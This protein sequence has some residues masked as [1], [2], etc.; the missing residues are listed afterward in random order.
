MSPKQR[1]AALVLIAGAAGVLA[2][3]CSANSSNDGFGGGSGGTD[4]TDASVGGTGGGSGGESGTG[5]TGG[6]MILPEA[7]ISD[8]VNETPVN[9][10]G[11]QCGPVELCEPQFIG[12]DDNCNGQVDEGCPCTPGLSHWCFKGDPASRN[13]GACK[14]G[15]QKCGENGTWGPCI[16]GFHADAIDNC[17]NQNVPD[18]CHDLTA[19]PFTTVT[20]KDGTGTF[21]QGATGESFQVTCPSSIPPANCPQTQNPDGPTATF[22]PLQLGQ[23]EVLYSKDDG[24]GGKATCTFS[25]YVGATGLRVELN[26]DHQ[27]E[28]KAGVDQNG[29]PDGT[30]GP[31]LDL[32]VHRPGVQSKWFMN[33]LQPFAPPD[34]CYYANC[35]AGN[36]VMAVP[37]MASPNWFSDT[38]YP[39]N[40]TYRQPY[41]PNDPIYTCY[42]A[43][44]GAGQE[45]KMFNKGCH[46]PRLDLDNITCDK[47]KTNPQDPAFC[48]PENINIDEPPYGL[49]TRIGV[50]YYG[51][52]YAGDLHPTVTIYCAGA[53]VAQ[54]GPN[55]Y[56]GP[57]TFKA[58][59]CQGDD[60]G[61]NAFW[62]VADVMAVE[63]PCGEVECVVQPIYGDLGTKAPYIKPTSFAKGNFGPACAP[64]GD[65]GVGCF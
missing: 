33:P 8:V 34:D 13:K 31:D 57:V 4:T 26:W 16:G 47:T 12:Y 19:A 65:A 56:D 14:D 27:G 40:W 42:N 23:Y 48:A 28:G 22:T 39:H 52:C 51:H 37:G 58:S 54:L 50:H 18:G 43:P 62:M 24:A 20:L 25:I 2:A 5:G 29:N 17:L 41:D 36:F 49:W 30:F 59:D 10:C 38:G 21:G 32:H 7:S 46:N 53:Q 35:T 45:W 63:G 64:A 3:N 44:R 60:N 1:F 55:G 11:S 6:S 61:N 9:L 15:T